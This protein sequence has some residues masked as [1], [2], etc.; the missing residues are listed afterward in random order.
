MSEQ[1][2]NSNS[3]TPPPEDNENSRDT[4]TSG[5]FSHFNL[6]QLFQEAEQTV[7]QIV[8]TKKKLKPDPEERLDAEQDSTDRDEMAVKYNEAIAALEELQQRYRRLE[9]EFQNYKNRTEKQLDNHAARAKAELLQN[10]VEILDIFQFAR[11]TFNSDSFSHSIDSYQKG[12][13][14]LYKQMDDLLGQMGMERIETEGQLFDPNFHQAAAM[15]ESDEF[16]EQTII[17]EIKAGYKYMGMLLRPSLVK[18]GIP[19]RTE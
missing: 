3:L 9:F 16:T 4:S 17:K 13:N 1:T 19:R 7:D 18:V 10:F 6:E 8:Q 5:N 15:E 14:L 12:F 2:E 11:K